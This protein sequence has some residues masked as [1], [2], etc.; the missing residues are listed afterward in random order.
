ME[1]E[2][3]LIKTY[4][5]NPWEN[6]DAI[7]SYSASE[8]VTVALAVQRYDLIPD[9]MPDPLDAYHT[10]LDSRQRSIVDKYRGWME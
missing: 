3:M 5:S 6:A 1:T 4:V 9:N 8:L 7:P 10:K 2:E